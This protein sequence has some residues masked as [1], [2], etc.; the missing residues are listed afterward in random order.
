MQS[1]LVIYYIMC[2]WNHEK[3]N[4]KSTRMK[5]KNKNTKQKTFAS[6]IKKIFFMELNHV[7]V[8]RDCVRVLC[9]NKMGKWELISTY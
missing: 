6:T 2:H 3:L 9:T 1:A 7:S 4:A 5:N 8:D